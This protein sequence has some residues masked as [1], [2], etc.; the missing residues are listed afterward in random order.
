[1]A[2]LPKFELRPP[3]HSPR[4]P[5][6]M[7]IRDLMRLQKAA[8]DIGSILD[9]DQLL[10]RIVN[11][12]AVMFGCLEASIWLH[13][14]ATNEMVLAAVRGCTMFGKNARLK[15]GEQGMIGQVA[16]TGQIRYA[17]DVRL[18]P[19]YIACEPG[20]LCE[21]DIPLLAEG[22]VIGVFSAV[23]PEV[24]AFPPQQVRLLQ[25]L[26][27]YIGIAVHNARRF[28]HERSEKERMRREAEEARSIQQALFPKSSPWVPGFAISGLCAPAGAVAGDWYDYIALPDG[29][30]GL[31]LADVSGKGMPAALLMSA[32]RGI[33]RSLTESV[34]APGA[35]LARLNEVLLRDFPSGKF[36]TMVYAVLDPAA[37]TMSF[38][39]AGH[40]WPLLA[41]DNGA[42][43]LQTDSGLPLGVTECSFEERQVELAPGSRV[44]FYTD[45]ITEAE[46]LQSAEFGA[47]RLQGL[48][49]QPDCCADTVVEEVRRFAG[50][51]ELA[52]DAT[53][54]LV[55]A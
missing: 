35:I 52:D 40:P 50:R 46:D 16:A 31:V 20:T 10:D 15:V 9:L 48:I 54:I 2:S 32:T 53:V 19:Y 8:Q 6:R 14:E 39:S 21:I 24:N 37:R 44:L 42:E 1:M 34:Q 27:N 49:A 3:T 29:R 17:P 36:V 12:T 18:D 7:N 41:R 51:H 30:W 11:E 5:Q 23:H 33:V 4:R 45:G 38:A 25:A 26:A 22:R 13:D 47:N 43:F 28:Q 55:K